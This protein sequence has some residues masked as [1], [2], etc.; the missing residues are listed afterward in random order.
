MSETVFVPTY[1]QHI[2]YNQLSKRVQELLDSDGHIY[3]CG[4]V[5]MADDVCTTVQKILEENSAMTSTESEAFIRNLKDSNRYHEDIFGV[6][7]NTKAVRE[8]A[9]SIEPAESTANGHNI[10]NGQ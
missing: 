1:V 8:A 7:L 6:T 5:A 3:V 10:G 4:D 2:L 9:R